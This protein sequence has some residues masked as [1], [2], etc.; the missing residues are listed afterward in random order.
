MSYKKTLILV[1]KTYLVQRF[2]VWTFFDQY[3]GIL[4]NII[5]AYGKKKLLP[6]ISTPYSS[7][8]SRWGKICWEDVYSML[9]GCTT[10]VSHSKPS[11]TVIKNSH[12]HNSP[13]S[14]NYIS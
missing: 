7:D 10:S 5:H 13:M 3:N 4:H 14:T 2:T 6:L 11:S 8:L 1:S 12:N 9:N